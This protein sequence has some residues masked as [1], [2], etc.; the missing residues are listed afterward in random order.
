MLGH[1]NTE[2]LDQLAEIEKC[3]NLNRPLNLEEKF[4]VKLREFDW[5]YRES[6]SG[7]IS[8]A[9]ARR[10]EELIA[11]IDDSDLDDAVKMKFL[12][13]FNASYEKQAEVLREYKWLAQMRYVDIHPE[14]GPLRLY[15]LGITDGQF[16]I[17]QKVKD[18]LD[19]LG[20]ILLNAGCTERLLLTD[21]CINFTLLREKA[22]EL[23]KEQKDYYFFGVAAPKEAQ[24]LIDDIVRNDKE[25]LVEMAENNSG[26]VL[27]RGF[28]IDSNNPGGVWH[29]SVQTNN[30]YRQSFGFYL[31]PQPTRARRTWVPRTREEDKGKDFNEKRNLIKERHEDV[32][33]YV[34]RPKGEG[35]VS[36]S[37][38][39][40]K[41][42]YTTPALPERKKAPMALSN[43]PM[44]VE[45]KPKPKVQK[46]APT[47]RK[48]FTKFVSLDQV[49]A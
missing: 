48:S 9:G 19:R 17:Y 49:K 8:R 3:R 42:T 31:N 12:N 45:D 39:A 41:T 4:A 14:S 25:T 20:N 47:K 15:F 1:L 35:Q 26:K 23:L 2:E 36:S 6:D 24:D 18:K 28:S 46:K 27:F 21:D 37:I 33:E 13:L 32:Q 5:T 10:E 44:V 16:N 7:A 22:M 29:V 43:R 40:V 30:D 34:D 11:E 38:A